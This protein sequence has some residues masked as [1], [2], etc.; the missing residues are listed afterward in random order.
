M[1]RLRMKL[2]YRRLTRAADAGDGGSIHGRLAS[3]H[4]YQRHTYRD[5]GPVSPFYQMLQGLTAISSDARTEYRDPQSQD[6]HRDGIIPAD[7][8]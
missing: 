1:R 3:P 2:R 8:C 6:I 7:L 4:P 5:V